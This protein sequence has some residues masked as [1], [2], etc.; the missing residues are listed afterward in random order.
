MNFGGN[1]KNH[2]LLFEK[3]LH[4][5]KLP[6][7]AFLKI[8][9]KLILYLMRIVQNMALDVGNNRRVFCPKV[10]PFFEVFPWC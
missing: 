3:L 8:N 4:I 2:H 1:G 10:E 6:I 9:F 7:K 5:S